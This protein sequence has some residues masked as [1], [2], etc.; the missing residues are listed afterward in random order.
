MA[1]FLEKSKKTQWGEQAL[2]QSTDF[3]ILVKID[4]LASD[5]QVLKRRALK[6]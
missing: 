5:K 1:T 3:E 2:H 6:K 4:P